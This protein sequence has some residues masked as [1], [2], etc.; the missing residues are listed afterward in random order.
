MV[1]ALIK[2][3]FLELWQSYFVD[4]K[5]GKTRNKG[6]IALSFFLFGLLMLVL[7]LAFFAMSAGLCA[8]LEG[9]NADWLYFALMALFSMALG[10]FGSVFNTYATVYL[11]KD[12][13]MLLSMPIPPAK[14]LLARVAGVFMTSL[15]YSALVWVP[16]IIAYWTVAEAGVLQVIYPVLL[17]FV[18][19]LFVTVLSCL[20]GFVVAAI[21]SKAKGK[22]FLTVLLSLAGIGLYYVFY[23]RISQS[24]NEIIQHIDEIGGVVQKLGY[25][26]WLGRAA[27]GDT[28]LM[29]LTVVITAALAALCLFVLSKTFLH[30]VFTKS[31]AQRKAARA[32]KDGVRS[33]RKALVMREYKHFAS[34]PVWMLNG[35]LGLLI[36]L[37]ASVFL[38]IKGGTV[39]QLF[40]ALNTDAPFLTASVPVIAAMATCLIISTN[41]I[42]PASVSME[43]KT[44]WLVQT[45]PVDAGDVLLAKSRMTV[46][47]SALPVMI[48]TL[49]AAIVLRFKPVAVILTLTTAISYLLMASNAGLFLNLKKPDLNWTNPA[50]VCKQGIPMFIYLFGGW[51]FCAAL[52]VIGFILSNIAGA[53]PVLI[54]Y[55]VLFTVLWLL[56]RRWLKKKGAAIM[57]TL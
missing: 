9:H 16:G 18:I 34:E 21:A 50:T 20:L 45:L 39:S 43:G 57:S 55:T 22:S 32:R 41:A 24:L 12:N 48:F 13:D 26:Y 56:L 28:V 44:M 6:K 4:R 37:A 25:V 11:P 52:G 14:L 51:G 10:I 19:A 2:K 8:N 46:E 29:L 27:E 47:L 7:A 53:V 23:F 42:T 17:T 3:Q 15:M 36:L 1:K 31:K 35:G 54:A 30:F 38:I 5:T 49:T 33:A 40:G